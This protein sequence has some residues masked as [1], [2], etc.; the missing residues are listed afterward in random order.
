MGIS[1]LMDIASTALNA[2]RMAL[3]VTGENITNVNTPGYSRQTAVLQ[4]MPT[5]LSSGFP[6]GNGV[7]VAA[8]QRYYDSFLQGQ[9]LT[10]NAA[11][12]QAT[13]TNSALQMV[14]PMFNDLTTDGLSQS[15]QDFF[16][17]WQDLSAN[18]Q[19]V[20]ERQV[21]LSTGQRLVEDFHRISSYLTDVK[22]SMNQSLQGLTAD[23]NDQ[24]NQVA[25][26][27]NSIKQAEV[28]GGEANELR[29]QR[30]LLIR[31]LS[32]NMGITSQEQLDG[33]VDVNLSTGQPLVTGASA[34]SLSLVP[35]PANSN[36]FDVMLTPPG[37]GAA[38]TATSFIGGP[39][40][41][42]SQGKIGGMLQVRDVT[43]NGYLASLDEVAA[44]LAGQVNTL[45]AAGFDLAGNTGLDFFTTPATAATIA[46]NF[47]SA[48][49]VAAA[50][51]DP[52]VGG[53]GNNRNSQKIAS[54]FDKP[55]AMTGGIMTMSDFY[56]S[57]V[58]TV[59]VDLQAAGRADIQSTS[60][61]LQLETLRESNS[62]VSLDEE[63]SNLM[64]YQKAYQGAA[65]VINVATDMLDTVLGLVR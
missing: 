39:G 10:G 13:T 41:S 52:A 48:S 18:A 9:L 33:S 43:V 23:I 31:Q 59:G 4:T 36:Y 17:A 35:D 50:D 55:I 6:M 44:T 34:A 19:G 22:D 53:T 57:L 64:K 61:V 15:L 37:G 40:G 65:K 62:G 1:N 2:Q 5:T 25:Q 47:T 32:S 38:V 8:I 56:T 45:H 60:M 14:Q 11:K 26:L 54:L 16:S 12:G 46:L 27:N 51:T 29:D 24:L 42:N 28:T 58:G 3:E 20:P 21:V 30:E 63:L 7:K 49:N